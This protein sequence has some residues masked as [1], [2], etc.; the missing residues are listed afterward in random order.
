LVVG[1]TGGGCRGC[2]IG[3]GGTRIRG[4]KEGLGSGD[5]DDAEEGNE[6]AE[7]FGAGKGFFEEDGAGPAGK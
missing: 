3:S 5:E 1:G 6:T 7:L 2:D 4:V